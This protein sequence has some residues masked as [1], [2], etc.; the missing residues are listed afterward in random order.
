MYNQLT[1]G[2][3]INADGPVTV[4]ADGKTFIAP[5][6]KLPAAPYSIRKASRWARTTA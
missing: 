3:V 4:I 5:N 6:G 2:L 1:G